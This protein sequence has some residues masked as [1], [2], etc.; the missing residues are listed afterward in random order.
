MLS[1]ENAA[2]LAASSTA[3]QLPHHVFVSPEEAFTLSKHFNWFQ[4]GTTNK[5]KLR[6]PADGF[7][8]NL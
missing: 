7:E 1:I 2:G 8:N 3:F 6:E 4:I 5:L